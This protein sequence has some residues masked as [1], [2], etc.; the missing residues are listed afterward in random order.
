MKRVSIFIL[1]A[2]LLVSFKISAQN[3]EP[4]QLNVIYKQLL[5][6]EPTNP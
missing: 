4:A 2:F 6:H 3:V 1:G 5:K